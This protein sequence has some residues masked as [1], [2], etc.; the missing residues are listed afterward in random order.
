MI[1]VDTNIWADHIGKPD[2]KLAKLVEA[3]DI[4]THPHVIGELALGNLRQFD[5]VIRY[6]KHMHQAT[7]A[8]E[9]EVLGLIRSHH[10]SGSGIGYCDAHLIASLLITPETLLWTRD[11]RLHAVAQRFGAAFSP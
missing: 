4:C 2:P 7:V 9:D 3:A 11:K 10:L 8:T 1:L 5:L 6:L